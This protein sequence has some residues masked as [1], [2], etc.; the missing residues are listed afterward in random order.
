MKTIELKI[1]PRKQ[2]VIALIQFFKPEAQSDELAKLS[3]DE[4]YDMYLKLRG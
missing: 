4:L 3:V 2:G 1:Q